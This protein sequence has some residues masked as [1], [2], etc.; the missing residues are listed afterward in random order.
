MVK[1][2]PICEKYKYLDMGGR[3]EAARPDFNLLEQKAREPDAI[4]VGLRDEIYSKAQHFGI[5]EIVR[6]TVDA[7]GHHPWNRSTTGV[8]GGD[9]ISKLVKF[10]KGGFSFQECSRAATVQR[11]PGRLGDF[12]EHKNMETVQASAGKLA[13]VVPGSLKQFSLTCGHTYQALRAA[14]AEIPCDIPSISRNGRISKAILSQRDPN[15]M[16]VAFKDGLDCLQFRWEVE[17]AFPEVIR[18]VMEADN[19][20]NSVSKQDNAVTLL[21][22]CHQAANA[23]KDLLVGENACTEAEYWAKVELR[24]TR[25]ELNREA[26]VPHY[27]EFVKDWSGGMSDPFVLKDLDNFVKTLPN[28]RELP[29]TIIGKLA[30]L[31]LGPTEGA[32]WRCA[33]IKS[34]LSSSD[35]YA[36]GNRSTFFTTGDIQSM[37]SAKLKPQVLAASAHMATARKISNCILG[38]KSVEVEGIKSTLDRKLVSH[39]INR[40][41]DATPGSRGLIEICQQFHQSLQKLGNG[42]DVKVECPADW[43]QQSSPAQTSSSSGEKRS[44]SSVLVALQPEGPSAIGAVKEAF[45]KRSCEVGS[46]CVHIKSKLTYKVLDI[47]VSNVKLEGLGRVDLFPKD[48]YKVTIDN[49]LFFDTFGKCKLVEKEDAN[50]CVYIQYI[51]IYMCVCSFFH[52]FMQIFLQF[53]DSLHIHIYM[54]MFCF[55]ST[56][57]YLS[58]ENPGFSPYEFVLREPWI[59][60]VRIRPARNPDSHLTNSSCE[61]PGCSPCEFVLREPWILTLRIR[62]ARTLDSYLANSSCE[63]PGFS[64]YEFVLREP[65]ILTLRIRPASPLRAASDYKSSIGL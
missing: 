12:Y 15:G 53:T 41:K 23:L 17:E 43:Q 54:C 22:K 29:S 24:V 46:Q 61:N 58:C 65:W 62:T 35:K 19:V 2:E 55:L 9:A 5:A 27:L 40:S 45:S 63:N 8:D 21:M 42:C 16:A 52:V 20:P 13:P 10:E 31:D 4:I 37:Q 28:V 34:M 64:P 44:A 36:S 18:L 1:F 32:W 49:A 6:E 59:L 60:T 26:E 51:Y 39:A 3:I 57:N 33:C 56:L 38:H 50:T 11:S 47:T 30:A 25:S 7:T 14:N 48:E